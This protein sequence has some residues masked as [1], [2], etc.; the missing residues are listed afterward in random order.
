MTEAD[1]SPSLWSQSRRFAD[2]LNELMAGVLPGELPQ[3]RAE[4]QEKRSS[5]LVS[6][7]PFPLRRRGEPEAFALLG[8]NFYCG[9]SSQKSILAVSKSSFRIRVPSGG[10]PV[11]HVDYVR[12]MKSPDK[13][14]AHYN[15]AS[16]HDGLL[17]MVDPEAAG[18]GS[19]QEAQQTRK[20]HLPVG[21]HRFRPSLEDVLGM[22]IGEFDIERRAGCEQV[23]REHR[24][25]FRDTQTAAAVRD[26][27]QTAI[28]ELRRLGY[29]IGPPGG[30]GREQPG[31]REAFHRF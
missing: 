22:L 21:G 13:P 10:P 29:E 14:V 24:S 4:D 8:V 7:S 25:Q 27:P 5:V 16:Q 6:A 9:W 17:R 20:L 18:D 19:H 15:V 26:N 28:R 12:D 11:L 23:L 31:R 30:E 3:F 1:T 2:Q